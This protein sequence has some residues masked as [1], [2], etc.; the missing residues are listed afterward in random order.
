M[1][2]V[3]LTHVQQKTAEVVTYTVVDGKPLLALWLPAGESGEVTFKGPNPLTKN[4][5]PTAHVNSTTDSHGNTV[6]SWS[7]GN[8]TAILHMHDGTTVLLMP[9]EDAYRLWAPSTSANLNESGESGKRIL[10]RGPYLVRSATFN[11]H[12]KTIEITG[13]GDSANQIEVFAPSHIQHIRWNNERL[14]TTS[15]EYGTLL[16]RVSAPSLT[17][18]ELE[19]Q[20]KFGKWRMAPDALPERLPSYDANSQAWVA[21]DKP[22]S[23][24]PNPLVRPGTDVVLFADEY[25]F[26]TGV[27][28]WRAEFDSSKGV[29]GIW[30]NVQG[31]TAFG[32]SLWL[33][34]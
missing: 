17:P 27:L 18:T 34:G 13:D 2:P 23:Q 9:R 1:K 33:N 24:S 6:L 19:D 30:V 25:G 29:G 3:R 4:Y 21:A 14:H 31:G 5:T 11:E 15:S 7:Q 12:G 22:A 8:S 20:I 28:I 32:Y 16:A 10:V 26:H